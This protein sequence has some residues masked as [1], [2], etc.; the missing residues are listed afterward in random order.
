MRSR[1]AQAIYI[2]D[3]VA[4]A[5]TEAL[6][7]EVVEGPAEII[8]ING[9]DYLEV[10]RIVLVANLYVAVTPAKKDTNQEYSHIFFAEYAEDVNGNAVYV[11]VTDD[12]TLAQLQE[13]AEELFRYVERSASAN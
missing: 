12:D 2:E 6:D 5:D 7:F 10:A 9:T 3:V 8:T 1:Q 11:H 13:R 4:N